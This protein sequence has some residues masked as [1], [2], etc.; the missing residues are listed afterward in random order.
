M[1]RNNSV[2]IKPL[3]KDSYDAWLKLWQSYLDFYNT[4]LPVSTTENTWQNL[5]NNEVPIYGFEA[6]RDSPCDAAS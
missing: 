2:Q 1:I 3:D 6:C 5:H 4:D